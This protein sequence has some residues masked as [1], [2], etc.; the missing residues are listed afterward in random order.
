VNAGESIVITKRGIP[1]AT[2]SPI[3]RNKKEGRSV[4]RLARLKK[5]FPDGPVKGNI[6]EVIDIERGER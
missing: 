3:K 5:L 6:S 4:D 2:V 1:F